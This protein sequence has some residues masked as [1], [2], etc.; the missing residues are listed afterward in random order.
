M[1]KISRP[2]GKVT[3]SDILNLGVRIWEGRIT[4]EGNDG[5]DALGYI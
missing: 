4:N 3:F 2:L 1:T 5:K